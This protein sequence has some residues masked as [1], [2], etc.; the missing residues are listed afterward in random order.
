L[1]LAYCCYG[2]AADLHGE[3]L[4]LILLDMLLPAKEEAFA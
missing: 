4:R 3:G 1:V 2:I